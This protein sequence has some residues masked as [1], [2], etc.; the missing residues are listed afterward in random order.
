MGWKGIRTWNSSRRGRLILGWRG[1]GFLPREN[2]KPKKDMPTRAWDMAP[3][4]DPSH[5]FIEYFAFLLGCHVSRLREHV[6][7]SR[8][9]DVNIQHRQLQAPGTLS[10]SIQMLQI[11][12][13]ENVAISCRVG[14]LAHHERKMVGEYT[15]LQ[16]QR[17]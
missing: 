10:R 5:H 7:F 17:D 9:I 11:T 15:H 2:R 3:G 1:L 16:R 8:Q 6:F 4:P 14:V 13:S 12:C